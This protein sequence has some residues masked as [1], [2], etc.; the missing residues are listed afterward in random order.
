MVHSPIC[1]ASDWSSIYHDSTTSLSLH[2]VFS[3]SLSLLEALAEG[4]KG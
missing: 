4:Q 2:K 3:G 1:R